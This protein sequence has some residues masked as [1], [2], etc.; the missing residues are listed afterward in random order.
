MSSPLSSGDSAAY[1]CRFRK[2]RAYMS[3]ADNTSSLVYDV[4]DSAANKDIP[5]RRERERTGKIVDTKARCK[6]LHRESMATQ[7]YGSRLRFFFTKGHL[8]I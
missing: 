5:G 4:L 1:T 6:T 8:S 7:L 2:T 3:R